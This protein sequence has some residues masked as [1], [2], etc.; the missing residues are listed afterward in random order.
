MEDTDGGMSISGLEDGTVIGLHDQYS[1]NTQSN[2]DNINDIGV[3]K[4]K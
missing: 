1:T 3:V 4:E 2:I